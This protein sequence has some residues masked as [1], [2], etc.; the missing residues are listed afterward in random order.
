MK[1]KDKGL[2]AVTGIAA[3]LLA[4]LFCA[5]AVSAITREEAVAYAL[6]HAESVRI[7]KESANEVAASGREAGSI[8]RPSISMDGDWM[9]L[10]TNATPYPPPYDM[11]N[12]PTQDIKAGVSASQ[13]LYAGDRLKSSLALQKNLEEQANYV[14]STGVRDI[15]KG[16]KNLFDA[17]LFYRAS[18]EIERDRVEQKKAEYRDARDLWEAGMVTGL[19]VRQ[20]QQSLHF[21]LAS[22]NAA[23]ANYTKSVLDLN[24][25]MGR[26]GSEELL[27]PEGDLSRAP[28][29][30]PMIE[31]ANKMLGEDELL[32]LK[33]TRNEMNGADLTYRIAKGGFYPQLALVGT[34]E[35]Q[36]DHSYDMDESWTLGLAASFN[37]YDGGAK[38]AKRAQAFARREKARETYSKKKKDLSATVL[39]LSVDLDSIERRVKLQEDSV[40][41]ARKNYEDAREQYRAGTITVT[42][43]GDYNL[44]YAESRFAL[45]QLYFLKRNLSTRAEALLTE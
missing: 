40:E 34:A 2:R 25:A 21:I 23:T 43:L 45:I 20:I 16:I 6:A 33:S 27:A 32:D 4:L 24:A 29:I 14:N 39:S 22:E 26:D 8:A 19:D 3:G 30:A 13:L 44:Y 37:I 38:Q 11:F 7:A 10:G 41:L 42:Q 36:G 1:I 9:A 18:A 35:T 31:Q 12:P 17:A 15:T 5:P 28:D